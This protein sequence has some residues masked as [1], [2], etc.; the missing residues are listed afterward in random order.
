MS[1]INR[2]HCMQ[3]STLVY[4][5]ALAKKELTKSIE[6]HHIWKSTF[7]GLFRFFRR[8]GNWWLLFFFP[9]LVNAGPQ[10]LWWT[11]RR[12]WQSARPLCSSWSC[13]AV[14]I[15]RNLPPHCRPLINLEGQISPSTFQVLWSLQEALHSDPPRLHL[16]F[17]L[18]REPRVRPMRALLRIYSKSAGAGQTATN[19]YELK[20]ALFMLALAFKAFIGH[21]RSL[22]T[23][24]IVKMHW[25]MIFRP[26]FIFLLYFL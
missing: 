5:C 18:P 20:N 10:R 11:M 8:K 7:S 4:Q 2:K 23:R 3:S 25:R 22:E 6:T 19:R 12:P 13:L 9:D 26:P 1:L 15:P 17:H 14:R 24:E 16:L 21:V